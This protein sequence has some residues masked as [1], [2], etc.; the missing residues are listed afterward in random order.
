MLR[1]IGAAALL[2]LLALAGLLLLTAQSGSPQR[3]SLFGVSAES[4]A[5]D[6]VEA[7]PQTT[8][9]K[10]SASEAENLA[11]GDSKREDPVAGTALIQLKHQYHPKFEGPAWVVAFDVGG[12]EA[13]LPGPPEAKD[14]ASYYTFDLVF[15][16]AIT[17]E[18]LFRLV[19]TSGAPD[20]QPFKP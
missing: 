18:W 10:I 17:G 7:Y 20:S 14:L 5:L 15:I 1:L 16:D 6:G 13:S 4:L 8:E 3:M 9:A 11:R 19:E 12:K 2:T